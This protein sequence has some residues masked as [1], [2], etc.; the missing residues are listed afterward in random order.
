[1]AFPLDRS[2][3]V[4]VGAR[5]NLD[6]L[7]TTPPPTVYEKCH[8][9]CTLCGLEYFKTYRAVYLGKNGCRCQN[10][11]SLPL[12]AYRKVEKQFQI[13]LVSPKPNNYSVPVE[14]YSTRTRKRVAISYADLY[15]MTKKTAAKL[16]ELGVRRTGVNSFEFI[17]TELGEPEE[18]Y[19]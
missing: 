13:S 8:W 9:R 17:Y 14:W 12:D 10:G 15:R 5:K 19:G 3:Y 6:F 1:M 16:E 2:K 11:M 4:S 7:D 18:V